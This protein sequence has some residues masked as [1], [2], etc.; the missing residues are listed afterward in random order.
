[1]RRLVGSPNADVTA[2]TAAENS[3]SVNGLLVLRLPGVKR[4]Y[5]IHGGIVPLAVVQI[6]EDAEPEESVPATEQC[7]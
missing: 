2:T 7:S 4:G 1:M 6:P 5:L 3:M